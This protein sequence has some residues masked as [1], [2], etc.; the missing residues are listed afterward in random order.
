MK[1]TEQILLICVS[2]TPQ[3]NITQSL[4]WSEGATSTVLKRLTKLTLLEKVERGHYQTTQKGMMY[5]IKQFKERDVNTISDTISTA[6]K[7]IAHFINEKHN[8][9]D[10]ILT[11]QIKL[12]ELTSETIH[13][14]F[15]S[16]QSNHAD[17]LFIMHMWDSHELLTCEQHGFDFKYSFKKNAN[18]T[19]IFS[20]NEIFDMLKINSTKLFVKDA[21]LKLGVYTN[22]NIN[23][24]KKQILLDVELKLGIHD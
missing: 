7:I 8:S 21:E 5:M 11:S 22:P 12:K 1:R 6:I 3:K 14:Y 20:T 10:N 23:T 9:F 4:G 16:V 17:A 13:L 19:K 24:I 15:D 18:L 2:K